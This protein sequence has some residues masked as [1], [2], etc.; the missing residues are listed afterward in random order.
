M[1]KKQQLF[2]S[3]EKN[4]KVIILDDLCG[5]GKTEA[6]IQ[7]VNK[8]PANQKFLWVTPFLEQVR[9]IKKSC[10]NKKFKEPSDKNKDG[11]KLTSLES[12]LANGDNVVTTHALLLL[13]D[14]E[15]DIPT[16]LKMGGYTLI[17]DECL[18][19]LVKIEITQNDIES[20][21][22]SKTPTINIDEETGKV[23]WVNPNYKGRLD[24]YKE[25]IE[26]NQ[27]Y[28][29][30]GTSMLWIFPIT[31]FQCFKSVYVLTY[32]WES[33][34]MSSWFE[35]NG[36]EIEKKSVEVVEP[37]YSC[38]FHFTKDNELNLNIQ[39]QYK[40]VDYVRRDVS[41][42]K[43][44]I[45]LVEDPKLNSIGNSLNKEKGWD[46][47]TYSKLTKMKKGSAIQK[48]INTTVYN[49]IRYR[50][51]AKSVDEVIWTA[52]KEC[53]E[54]KLVNPRS[55]S[56]AFVPSTI[57]ATNL[58]SNTRVVCFCLNVYVNPTFTNYFGSHGITVNEDLYALSQL[59][60]FVYRSRIRK[61]EKIQLFIPSERM[62]NLFKRFLN[63]EI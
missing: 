20:L 36:I 6:M 49:F 26:S 27:V 34:L 39:P 33:S 57:R 50:A 46:A 62:R 30:N 19:P 54:Q 31:L 9:R 29:F 44:L 16:L 28:C 7:L 25:Q 47:L 11:S 3:L 17:L 48:K 8:S 37:N 32:I 63:N 15:G 40:I 38:N 52:P 53:Y 14:P 59:I 2:D 55:Y 4:Q 35:L 1:E 61:G 41:H 43:E 12:L 51:K 5:S 22:T 10:M 13:I 18:D 23:T 21:A 42:L 24:V 45:E 58:Y 56:T 60:Q